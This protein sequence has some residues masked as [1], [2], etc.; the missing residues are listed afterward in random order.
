MSGINE[1]LWEFPTDHNFKVMGRSSY[2]LTNI[3][4]EIVKKYAPDFDETRITVK[5]SRNGKF[6]SIT[7]IVYI[8]DKT[9]LE[10]IYREFSERKEI[11]CTL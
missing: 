3:V 2:P 7:A 6:D 9:Q 4:I 10:N 11:S 5:S 8:T 1:D